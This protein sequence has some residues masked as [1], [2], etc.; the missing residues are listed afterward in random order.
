MRKWLIL[1]GSMSVTALADQ[2]SKQWILAN[3]GVYESAQPLPA[4][5]PFF[6]LTRSS[7]T[8]AAFGILPMAGDVFLVIALLIIAGLLWYFR[9]APADGRLAPIAIGLVIG[10]AAG[11]VLD[12]LQHG[13]VID[14][15]HYQ[16]PNLISNVSNLADHA[17]VFGVLLVIAESLWRD[18]RERR[19]QTADADASGDN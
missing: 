6:Q 3:L 18:Y 16:I 8:G 4:L 11:N 12:R 5:A 7:N 9:E 13:H 14:F 10:G 19:S 15:I 17:I 1:G 2:A